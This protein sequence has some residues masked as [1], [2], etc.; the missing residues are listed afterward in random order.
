MWLRVHDLAPTFFF[1]CFLAFDLEII[2]DSLNNYKCSTPLA[3]RF[4]YTEVV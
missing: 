2:L 3:V 4:L 1:F